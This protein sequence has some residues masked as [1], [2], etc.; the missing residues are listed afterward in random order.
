M[1]TLEQWP[2]G[3]LRLQNPFARLALFPPSWILSIFDPSYSCLLI[4]DLTWQLATSC[5]RACVH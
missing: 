5:V 2:A 3:A 4:S 1:S